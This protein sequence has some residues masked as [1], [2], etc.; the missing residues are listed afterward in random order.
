MVTGPVL[1]PD[2]ISWHR[3][4]PFQ[5]IPIPHAVSSPLTPRSVGWFSTTSSDSM[6][7]WLLLSSTNRSNKWGNGKATK[8]TTEI[9]I[10]LIHIHL[11]QHTLSPQFP[12][13]RA[14]DSL[15]QPSLMRCWHF[16][17]VSMMRFPFPHQLYLLVRCQMW[18][19]VQRNVLASGVKGKASL[20][21]GSFA[22]EGCSAPGHSRAKITMTRVHSRGRLDGNGKEEAA[23]SACNEKNLISISQQIYPQ[24]SQVRARY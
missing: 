1:P 9:D 24:S 20:V 15:S 16:E 2:S 7:H 12:F 21:A 6:A 5:I 13:I 23:V 3:P 22:V 8:R 11:I 17:W 18:R 10:C 14:N 4:D 19:Q